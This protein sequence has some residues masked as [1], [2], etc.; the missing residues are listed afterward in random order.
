MLRYGIAIALMVIV[1]VLLTVLPVEPIEPSELENVFDVNP[2][3]SV[4]EVVLCGI[5]TPP[6]PIEE[7]EVE[8][9]DIVATAYCSCKKCCG[10]WAENR[11]NGI[12]YT[13]SG[14]EAVQGVTIAADWS[15]YPS[16]TVLYI[17]GLGE[18]IVHDKGGAIKGNRIDVYFS[19]HE[20]ALQ[21]GR[22]ELKARVIE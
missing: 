1:I 19:D 8:W 11:P 3:E 20:E 5:V 17:D 12:V 21:F 7:P 6:E 4:E 10:V 2:V 14:E 16:G 22:Q 15:V 18:R 9:D 13:A